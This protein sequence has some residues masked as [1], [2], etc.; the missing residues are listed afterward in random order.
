MTDKSVAWVWSH[1]KA[2]VT[3]AQE[4][5]AGSQPPSPAEDNVIPFKRVNDDAQETGGQ[6]FAARRIKFGTAL[7]LATLAGLFFPKIGILLLVFGAL[8]VASSREP[9]KTEAFLAAVPGGSF[10]NKFLGQVDN[11]LG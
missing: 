5:S 6:A 1:Y 4:T 2:V 8:L 7:G 3:E 10:A 9:A 11:W